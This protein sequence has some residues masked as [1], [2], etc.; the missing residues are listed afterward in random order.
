MDGAAASD[1]ESDVTTNGEG[2]DG[3]DGA[4]GVEGVAGAGALA[5]DS[6]D[7]MPKGE[8]ED[9]GADSGDVPVPGALPKGEAEVAGADSGI[10]PGPGVFPKGEEPDTDG[11]EE[12][13]NNDMANPM[14]ELP[15]EEG[16]AAGPGETETAAP[17]AVDEAPSVAAVD[18][19]CVGGRSLPTSF[20]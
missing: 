13:L 18:D 12:P 9:A 10:V 14:G 19:S 15:V 17:G 16:A 4:V 3:V 11:A 1:P 5:G 7:V 8:A 6:D 20:M 2:P